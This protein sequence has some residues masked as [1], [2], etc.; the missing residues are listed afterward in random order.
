MNFGWIQRADSPGFCPHRVFGDIRAAV[1]AATD[2]KIS[3][4]LQFA[5]R[6]AKSRPGHTRRS[7]S[8]RSGGSL[9]AGAK[10]PSLIVCRMCSMVSSKA[11]PP[12]T[13]RNIEYGCCNKKSAKAS[14]QN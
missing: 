3:G 11:F 12:R 7:A 4:S 13:G 5:Q 2:V 6:L 1:A 10:I 14:S 9:S 8:S